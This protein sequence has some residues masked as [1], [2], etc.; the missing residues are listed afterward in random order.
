[1][2]QRHAAKRALDLACECRSFAALDI[3]DRFTIWDGRAVI[4]IPS[5]FSFKWGG[6]VLLLTAK[7]DSAMDISEMARALGRNG[8]KARAAR[9]LPA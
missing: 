4:R 9:L 3:L 6:I 8:G 2:A 5:P 1:V 7:D